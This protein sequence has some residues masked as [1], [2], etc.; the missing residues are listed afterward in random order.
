M[1]FLM[2]SHTSRKVEGIAHLTLF[3]TQYLFSLTCSTYVSHHSASVYG[4]S[5]E[6]HVSCVECSCAEVIEEPC[7]LG[8]KGFCLAFSYIFTNVNPEFQP[9][10]DCLFV[11]CWILP[12]PWLSLI[13]SFTFYA[14]IQYHAMQH[15]IFL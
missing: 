1:I 9:V 2:G 5:A 6:H 10:K 11:C 3:F 12:V 8:R 4:R 14:W 7:T 13:S 15:I